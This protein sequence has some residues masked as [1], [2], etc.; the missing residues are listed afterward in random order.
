M[1]STS[2][3]PP[4]T[5]YSSTSPGFVGGGARQG[6]GGAWQGGG[7]AWQGGGLLTRALMSFVIS[8]GGVRVIGAPSIYMGV[9]IQAVLKQTGPPCSILLDLE[10]CRV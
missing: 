3:S 8:R 5:L 6:G 9:M 7:G 4:T 10:E 2:L 1:E